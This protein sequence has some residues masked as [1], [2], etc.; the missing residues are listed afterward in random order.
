M[1]KHPESLLITAVILVSPYSYYK[2][3]MGSQLMESGSDNLS[4][5]NLDRRSERV[6]EKKPKLS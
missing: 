4:E 5:G 1:S 3:A 2:Q 6:G